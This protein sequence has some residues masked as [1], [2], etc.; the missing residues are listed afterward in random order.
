MTPSAFR[1][2]RRFVAATIIGSA[3]ALST[4]L[5]KGTRLE[6]QDWDCPPAGS[7]ARPVVVSGFPFV[8]IS[9]FHGIS[10]VGDASLVSAL[11]GDDHFHRGPFLLNAGVYAL[12]AWLLF[13]AAAR[14][15]RRADR[16]P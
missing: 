2:L 1:R 10:V 9:D 3:V 7:C 13:E 6:T 5:V 11:L 15:A 14:R 4:S 16:A 12:I 8:F